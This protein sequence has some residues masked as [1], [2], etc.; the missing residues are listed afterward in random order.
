MRLRLSSMPRCLASLALLALPAATPAPAGTIPYTEALI[1]TFNPS[2]TNTFISIHSAPAIASTQS[3]A[4]SGD[5]GSVSA[6]ASADL[7]TGQ[8]KVRA[9][10]A[11]EAGISPYMQANAWFGDGFRTT[12]AG[13][14][15]FQWLPNTGAR[16]TMDLTGSSVTSSP[17]Q[18][19]ELGFG[20]VGAFVLLSLYQPGTLQPGG[21]LVGGANNI[22]YYLYL[23]GNPNQNL[24][25]TDPQGV[26][27]SLLPTA[28]YGD[29]TKDIHIAQDFQ[30]GGDFDWV[31]LVGASGQLTGPQFYDMDLSHT[32][33]V[34][35]SGPAGATS[36]S[37][38]G[39][40]PGTQA[41]PEPASIQMLTL[42][43]ASAAGLALRRR[44]TTRLA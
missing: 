4:R 29:L 23:L 3:Y 7:S 43:L 19:A 34:G 5:W 9:A 17:L 6:F 8:L 31:I 2:E 37:V 20:Q 36:Q 35:Y 25:Y 41:V 30:P 10:N 12:D 11:P 16:F 15:P 24:T 1:S 13:G 44:R 33:T 14:S 27:H 21:K 28:Y 18:L 40:F 38:S 32:L 22:G 42:G 39:L 26:G